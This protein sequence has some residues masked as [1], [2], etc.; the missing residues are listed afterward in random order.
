MKSVCLFVF[1]FIF[2]LNVSAAVGVDE[3]NGFDLAVISGEYTNTNGDVAEVIVTPVDD[4]G[5]GQLSLF[6]PTGYDVE[7]S[8]TDKATGQE[9]WLGAS[10]FE[11]VDE[12][13]TVTFSNSSECEDPGCTWGTENLVFE[14]T[15]E[16]YKL[17]SEIEFN[18][19]V[20]ENFEWDF[21]SEE[22][23]TDEAVAEYCKQ[24]YGPEAYG[25]FSGSVYCY[26]SIE[27]ELTRK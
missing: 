1:G 4:D 27:S 6:G 19:E 18:A 3:L 24:N 13:G 8:Y 10:S 5:D 14:K 15:A 17:K 20:S 11:G 9:F 22:N 2:A 26:L 12:N 16:G 7:I 23:P 21:D 25:E